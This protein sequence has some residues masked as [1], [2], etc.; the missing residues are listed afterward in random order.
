MKLFRDAKGRFIR[1]PNLPPV[2]QEPIETPIETGFKGTNEAGYC[3][4]TKYILGRKYTIREDPVL[5][6]RGYHYCTRPVDVFSYYGPA[7]AR[8]FTV[9]AY[10][11][12][13]TGSRC[14]AG[15]EANPNVVDYQPNDSKR[16]AKAIRLVKEISTAEMVRAQWSMDMQRALAVVV[17]PETYQNGITPADTV[18][19]VKSSDTS[20][21]VYVTRS[22]AASAR[23]AFIEHGAS[24]TVSLATR[25][26]SLCN[27]CGS[28]AITMGG[29][30][31]AYAKGRSSIAIA[32][33]SQSVAMT[34]GDNSIAISCHSN[35]ILVSSGRHSIAIMP[36][37]GGDIEVYGDDSVSIATSNNVYTHGKNNV[38]VFRSTDEWG[39]FGKFKE[40][41]LVVFMREKNTPIAFRIGKDVPLQDEYTIPE[42]RKAAEKAQRH[43][44]LI[45]NPS[46]VKLVNVREEITNLL[47]TINLWKE[48]KDDIYMNSVKVSL[49]E[50]LKTIDD[51]LWKGKKKNGQTH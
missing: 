16:A 17:P 7:A 12:V 42:L 29:I 43:A 26:T 24:C 50:I 39:K 25:S 40:G 30:S 1:D 23:E 35:N 4:R 2:P 5:C 45:K 21:R 3:Q 48:R 41:T 11:K 51:S 31:M 6:S 9:E 44:A 33:S 34:D 32:N 49:N 37:V 28:I 38:V 18:Y 10:G 14:A 19:S 22:A 20:A 47:E 15:Y 46:H 36:Y 13:V 8:F 27:L